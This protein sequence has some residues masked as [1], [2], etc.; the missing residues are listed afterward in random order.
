MRIII[1]FM[2]SFLMVFSF[3]GCQAQVEE[4]TF[5]E[6]VKLDQETL[7]SY[8]SAMTAVP[9]GSE[10]KAVIVHTQG[11]PITSLE[12]E[13]MAEMFSMVANLEEY[14]YVN[15]HQYQTLYPEKFTGDAITFE[16]A[17]EYDEL[18]VE[19]LANVLYT[20][21]EN[22]P[23]RPIYL[24]GESFGALMTQ[25]LIADYGTGLADKYGISVGR[26]TMPDQFVTWFSEGS[27]GR[28][29]NA[30]DL[31]RVEDETQ[32]EKNM[33]KMAAGLGYLRYTE[34]MKG[35]DL[36]KV[37]YAYGTGDTYVGKLTEEE[38]KFLKDH[39][40]TVISSDADH[41]EAID[42]TIHDVFKFFGIE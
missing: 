7:Y 40:A 17:K 33:N 29:D 39:K 41:S 25:A 13:M 37:I 15:V 5:K 28:F 27:N 22:N 31:R 30:T 9:E 3:V 12:D 1:I 14:L 35:M 18:S 11:G 24:F 26:M 8:V 36:S 38:I 20:L 23:D 6:A 4:K 2:M 42:G 21:R 32:L 19:M 16:Q 10:P 34:L